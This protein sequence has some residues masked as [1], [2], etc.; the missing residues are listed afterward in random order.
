MNTGRACRG[1]WPS[2]ACPGVRGRACGR[3]SV[4]GRVSERQP[5]RGGVGV[6]DVR[7]AEG[8]RSPDSLPPVA[9]V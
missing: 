4:R 9:R 7:G 8:M 3:V 5:G 2:E 1:A 6:R